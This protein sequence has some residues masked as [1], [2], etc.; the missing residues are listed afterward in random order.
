MAGLRRYRIG[1]RGLFL[2]LF[3]IAY[4]LIG[5]ALIK[6]DVT[7][8]INHLFRFATFFMPIYGWGIAWVVCGCIAILD[9]LWHRGTDIIGFTVAVL[10]PLAWSIV[11]LAAWIQEDRPHS[12][13]WQS[14]LLYAVLAGAVLIVAGMP[15]PRLMC[16]VADKAGHATDKAPDA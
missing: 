9:G 13:L 14:S 12:N 2:A 4:L 3:G 7:P 8:E 16:V 11:Y 10:I 6:V 15:E 5:Q 1:R